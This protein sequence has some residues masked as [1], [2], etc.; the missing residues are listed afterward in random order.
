M[1]EQH[2]A[3]L[4]AV[5][6]G[7][8]REV[9]DHIG[10]LLDYLRSSG[11]YDDTLILVTADHGEMLGDQYLWGKSCPFD[12]A[13]RIPLI[14]RDPRRPVS[15]GTHVDAF[16]ESVDLAPTLASWAGAVMPGSF[17]GRSLLPWLSGPR[18]E[19]WREHVF[20]EAELGEPDTATRFQRA[21]DLPA[22]QSNYAVLR[23]ATHKYVHFNGGLPP[24]LYDLVSDPQE[25][26]NLASNPA[27]TT[28]LFTL[29]SSML[30]HRMSF[31]HRALSQCRL[32][33]QGVFV[34]G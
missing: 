26:D 25:Q 3:E 32:T 5:Y 21:W 7:L 11:Q 1:A 9:D 10:R 34:G 28:D 2:V 33:D 15:F 31:A 12:A 6:L 14:I 18:P 23:T 27:Y 17:D 22:R 19:R 29:A 24:L 30:N 13:L 16:T 8:A 20:S 4:R